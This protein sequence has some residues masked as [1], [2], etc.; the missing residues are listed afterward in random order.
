MSSRRRRSK[1]VNDRYDTKTIAFWSFMVVA[2]VAAAVMYFAAEQKT[3]AVNAGPQYTPNIAAATG[4]QSLS[5]LPDL[6]AD[7]ARPITI[8]ILGDS[9]GN[10]QGEWVYL[11]AKKVQADY[12]RPVTVHDWSIEANAYVG[13]NT[14]GVASTAAPVEIWNGSAS[15]KDA[16]YTIANYQALAPAPSDLVFINHGHNHTNPQSTVAGVRELVR[17]S[18][19]G[20]QPPPAIGVVLQNPRVDGSAEN[21]AA[22]IDTIRQT[23]DEWSGVEVV[24]VYTAFEERGDVRPLLRPDGFHPSDEGSLVWAAVTEQALGLP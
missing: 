20:T 6:L 1:P 11:V 16:S 2:I 23:F 14:F 3:P 5:A 21:Q 10:E 17:L 4:S 15:G 9:T 19:A 24:D 8:T 13:E 7:P 12:R 22:K 18:R